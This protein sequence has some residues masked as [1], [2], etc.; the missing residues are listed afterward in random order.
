MIQKEQPNEKK[1]AVISSQTVSL[2]RFR[3][4]MMRG[5]RS[6]GYQVIAVGP[7][8]VEEW[9]QKF[10]LHGIQYYKISVERTGI[11]PIRDIGTIIDIYRFLKREKPT[12]V[13]C[14]QA[15]TIVYTCLAA[16]MVRMQEVYPLIAGLGSV[17]RGTSIIEKVLKVILTLEYKLALRGSTAVIFQN[18]DDLT[19][20]V[21]GGIV[22]R[23]KCY[24]INGSGVDVEKFFPTPMPHR[25]TF[26]MITRLIKDK[27]VMEFLGACRIIKK[28][29]PQTRCILVGPFDTNPS[30]MS[31]EELQDYLD[32]Q[33]VEYFGEQEDVKPFIAQ[34][35]VFVLPSYHEG[36][37]KSV[38]ECMAC[39]RAI[40]TTD[41]PGCRETVID[42][43]NGFRVP[44][45]NTEAIADK[46]RMFVEDQ[47][48]AERM[49]QAGRRIAI[50]KYDVRKVNQDIFRIMKIQ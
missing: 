27:G 46:M 40:I 32:D 12:K 17:F 16:K 13:F 11:N 2:C 39:G 22:K 38:L 29:S 30:A 35:S 10:S 3:M 21:D 43:I 24:K 14:Y 20:F 28:E 23:E 44:T 37:P 6:F 49:G 7:D 8:P 1:I 36:T 5:F 41:A 15:K 18:N 42:G 26:L 31:A 33:T 4:D 47:S 9:A 50:N 48:L 25:P 19:A 34:S 45:R